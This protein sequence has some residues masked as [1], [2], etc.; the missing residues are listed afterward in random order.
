MVALTL[1]R[2]GNEI[3]CE[4]RDKRWQIVKPADAKVP[5][6]LVSA[7]IENLT[8]KQEAEEIS[9]S[10][11]PEDLQTFGLSDASPEIEVD[12][13]FNGRRSS[14]G[15]LRSGCQLASSSRTDDR[16][17]SRRIQNPAYRPA[18]V[19]KRAARNP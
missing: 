12:L 1:R 10:P 7:L 11:K 19:R 2:E 14:R 3:R 6:D 8:D 18:S 4:R 15:R 9:A 5:A 13:D 17:P 16:R